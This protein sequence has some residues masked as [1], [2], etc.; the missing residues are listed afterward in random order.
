MQNNSR[1]ATVI[2][3]AS[4]AKAAHLSVSLSVKLEQVVQCSVVDAAVC[5]LP[6]V[7]AAHGVS[8]TAARLAI[9]MSTHRARDRQVSIRQAGSNKFKY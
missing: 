5:I 8:F 3:A 4:K 7:S 2:Q 1:K 9:C 6:N